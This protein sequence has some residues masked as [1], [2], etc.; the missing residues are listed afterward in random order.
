MPIK[1][2]SQPFPEFHSPESGEVFALSASCTA[3]CEEFICDSDGQEVGNHVV[4][5]IAATQSDGQWTENLVNDAN[6][7]FGNSSIGDG[8]HSERNVWLTFANVPL[9]QGV[10]RIHKARLVLTASNGV[11]GANANDY[12]RVI[13]TGHCDSD[14]TEEPENN[15]TPNY[16][17]SWPRTWTFINW[18]DVEHW[19]DNTE[20]YSP[21]VACIVAEIVSLD[22]WETGNSLKLFVEERDSSSGVSSA[23]R[24]FYDY[25]TDSTKAAKL[26]LWYSNVWNETPSGGVVCGG[27]AVPFTT[28]APQIDSYGVILN[29][30]A[31]QPLIM[32]GGVIC[33]GS[34]SYGLLLTETPS[35]G[36]ICGGAAYA[37]SFQLI[38]TY[39]VKITVP[40]GTVASDLEGFILGIAPTLDTSHVNVAVFKVT[41]MAGNVLAHELRHYDS[42]TGQAHLFF[43]TDLSASVDNEFWLYYGVTLT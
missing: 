6:C 9:T 31:E 34:A 15:D 27:S 41:D 24:R 7:E 4:L 14:S 8:S 18:D 2:F 39:R 40:A 5:Q 37:V 1:T 3:C 25:A 20:Y 13:I 38:F 30:T 29:G 17:P 42:D 16:E 12:V 36:V 23:T 26:E 22:G 43:R 11:E 10:S 19:T 28:F 32:D 21:D 33:G 35:G